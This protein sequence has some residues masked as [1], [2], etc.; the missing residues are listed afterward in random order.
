MA[1]KSLA[2]YR[3]LQRLPA[4]GWLFT[5]AICFKAPYFASISPRIELLEP[6]RCEV[7]L[8]HRRKVTNHIGSVHAIAL[9]NMAELAGGMVTEVSL[10]DSMRWIPKGMTVEY[11]KKAIGTMRAVAIPTIPVVESSEG[12][13]LPVDVVVTDSKS[14]T[15]FR[16]TISMWLSPKRPS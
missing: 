8:R 11:V 10:P 2:L 12:Y 7:M 5:R 4:G 3:R 16:A 15:V 6:N 1:N 13:A 14:D 9:C